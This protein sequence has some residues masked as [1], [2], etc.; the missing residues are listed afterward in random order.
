MKTVQIHEITFESSKKSFE[1]KNYPNEGLFIVEDLEINLTDIRF[2]NKETNFVLGIAPDDLFFR[3]CKPTTIINKQNPD[4]E[5]KSVFNSE[6]DQ[7]FILEFTKLLL[8]RK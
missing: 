7:N 4:P 3:L 2:V 6:I 1:S 5:L 8:N